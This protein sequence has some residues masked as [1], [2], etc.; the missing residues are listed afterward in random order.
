[1]LA[2]QSAK[3]LARVVELA[4]G[5]F[6]HGAAAWDRAGREGRPEV[7]NLIAAAASP[8]DERMQQPKH[9]LSGARWI[10]RGHIGLMSDY[11]R[12]LEKLERAEMKRVESV[13]E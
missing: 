9:I 10:A 8:S 11:I 6:E 4:F 1:V 7:S 13:R 5:N 3:R 12:D 2:T